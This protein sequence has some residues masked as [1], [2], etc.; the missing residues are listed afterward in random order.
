MQSIRGMHD[1]LPEEIIYWQHIYSTAHKILGLANYKEIRTPLLEQ[2]ELFLRSIGD[3]TDIINKEMY[4]FNDQGNRSLTL[5]PE[6]TA[7]IARALLQH[8][9]HK[10]QAIQKLW[11]L[12]PMFRYERPQQGRQRQFHQLGIECYG[13]NDAIL[14]AEIIYLATRILSSFNFDDYIVEINSIGSLEDRIKYRHELK[15]YLHK[16]HD[17]L[18]DESKQYLE[19]NPIRILDT[20]KNKIQDILHEA[21]KLNQFLNT[22]SKIHFTQVIEYL[23]SFNIRYKINPNLVRGLD[24]YNNTVFEVKTKQLG[25]QDTIC[26]GGR[27]NNLT[28]QLGGQTIPAA[29]WGIGI[30]RLLLI[31]KD[32]I[33]IDPDIL[34]IYLITKSHEGIKY[35]LTLIP[36]FHEYD[37]KYEIDLSSSSLQKQIKKASKKK[38]K[39]CVII[40]EDEVLNNCITVKWLDTYKQKSYSLSDFKEEIKLLKKNILYK[41]NSINN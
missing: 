40:D 25:T 33:L 2:T 13:S 41:H 37:L 14:D 38:A 7:S 8:K 9:L 20:K 10:L 34:Y 15:N 18:D 21:P 24:Y 6:G 3:D 35:G 32:K 27:Y 23:N 26:G 11:Y 36:I 1:I 17:S 4:S 29:G 5:R 30:E 19:T 28:K 39:I 12:G 16:Y 31:A 22:E